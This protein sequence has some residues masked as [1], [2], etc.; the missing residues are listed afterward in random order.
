MTPGDVIGA[1]LAENIIDRL[2]DAFPRAATE[3]AQIEALAKRSGVG[4]E[5]IRGIMRLERSPRL[6]TID[7]IARALGTS[8]S[9]LITIPRNTAGAIGDMHKE[10]PSRR[11]E[12]L[13]RRSG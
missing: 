2:S 12:V 10:H 5:T 13:Q 3:T 11:H 1:L 4:E 9:E 6:E 7:A 8:A